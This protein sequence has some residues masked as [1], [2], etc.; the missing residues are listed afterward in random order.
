SKVKLTPSGGLLEQIEVQYGGDDRPIKLTGTAQVKFGKGGRFDGGMSARQIDL[1]RP[2]VLPEG[3]R[4]VPAAVLRRAGEAS[5]G[6]L[7]PPMPVRLG[8]GIDSVTLAGATLQNLRGDVASDGEGWNVENFEFRAPGMT[9]VHASGRMAFMG[10]AARFTGP[11]VVE[12][13]DPR[14][15][16]GWLEA[17][18]DALPAQTGP[19]R[20]SGDLA[21]GS[22]RIAVERLNAAGDRKTV[23]GRLAYSWAGSD[24]PARLD[25]ALTATE[26][27]IDQAVGFTRAALAG[28]TL[29]APG[30]AALAVDIGVA[31]IGGVE[32]KQARAKLN[33]DANGLVLERVAVADLGGA[34]LDLNGR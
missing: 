14:A 26:L 6:L 28:A 31:T 22:D 33:F 30:E 12:S 10:E 11:A 34:S 13:S 3:T 18:A 16:V 27:D 19:L 20:A 4:R 1:D 5:G 23:T 32:A 24:H 8:H 17:R 25:A 21:L 29:D 9:Q 15:L 7:A 2:F